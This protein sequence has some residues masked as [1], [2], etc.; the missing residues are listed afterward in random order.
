MRFDDHC[1]NLCMKCAGR[2][3]QLPQQNNITL[4]RT[5]ESNKERYVLTT[6]PQKII[7]FEFCEICYVILV[8]KVTPGFF[9]RYT[10]LFRVFR[11]GMV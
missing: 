1:P 3:Y 5:L 2:R 9:K 11:L 8:T 6:K 4:L 10:S 7:F